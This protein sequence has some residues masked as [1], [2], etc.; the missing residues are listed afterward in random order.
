MGYS[1]PKPP[2]P[3]DAPSVRCVYCDRVPWPAD[4]T[5]AGCGAPVTA[6]ADRM[7]RPGEL[8]TRDVGTDSTGP[9]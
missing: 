1:P 8:M 7:V 9:K 2:P 3:Q 6:P 5:C 4:R